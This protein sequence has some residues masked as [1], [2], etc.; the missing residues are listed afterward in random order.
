MPVEGS[1]PLI[2]ESLLSVKVMWS[3]VRVNLTDEAD[4]LRPRPLHSAG[5]VG[6]A[7]MEVFRAGR[8]NVLLL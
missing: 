1:E 5:S 2:S 6:G 3:Q 7:F 4:I 8:S